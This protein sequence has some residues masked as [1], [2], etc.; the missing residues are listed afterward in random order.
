MKIVEAR[1]RGTSNISVKEK[2]SFIIQFQHYSKKTSCKNSFNSKFLYHIKKEI[3][4]IKLNKNKRTI[5][6]IL[7]NDKYS[8]KNKEQS[9]VGRTASGGNTT[10][11]TLSAC[12]VT[13]GVIQN[14]AEK[15]K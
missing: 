11:A 2:L 6:T 7:N 8:L 14:E 12:I 5:I 9:N 1:K 4:R 13:A 10:I 3:Y 15:V